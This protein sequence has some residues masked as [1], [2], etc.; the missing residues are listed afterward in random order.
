MLKGENVCCS[1]LNKITI[2]PRLKLR[3]EL[4]LLALRL[5][6]LISGHYPNKVPFWLLNSNKCMLSL[7]DIM[8][9][10]FVFVIPFSKQMMNG[11]AKEKDENEE[12]CNNVNGLGQ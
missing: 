6:C 3:H 11:K 12:K 7:R 4:F 10:V 5:L 8:L 1:H 2:I 9:F